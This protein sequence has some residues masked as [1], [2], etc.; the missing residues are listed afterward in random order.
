[1]R[2]GIEL[3]TTVAG[4]I[5]PAPWRREGLSRRFIALS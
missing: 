4:M 2:V 3:M 1:M 5:V